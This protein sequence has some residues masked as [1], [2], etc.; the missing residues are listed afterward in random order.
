MQVRDSRGLHFNHFDNPRLTRILR[1]EMQPQYR[2]VS[3]ITLR[4]DALKYWEIARKDM[5]MSFLNLKSGVSLTCDVWSSIGT[6][7]KSYLAVT[8]HWVDP[9]T[10]IMNKRVIS[11]EHFC[12]SS[13]GGAVICNCSCRYKYL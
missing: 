11:F 4:R 2:Q 10:W 5:Q 7:S 9:T 1:K 13:H 8:A 3:R 12:L 6:I